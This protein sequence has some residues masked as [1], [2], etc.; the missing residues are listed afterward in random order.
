MDFKNMMM[1]LKYGEIWFS[2]NIQSK[3]ATISERNVSKKKT[4]FLQTEG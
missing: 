3:W 1:A 4:S 2:L